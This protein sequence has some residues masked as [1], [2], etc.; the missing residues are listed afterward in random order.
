[1]VCGLFLLVTTVGSVIKMANLVGMMAFVCAVAGRVDSERHHGVYI[2]YGIKIAC[3]YVNIVHTA[4]TLMDKVIVVDAVAIGLH[5]LAS[6]SGRSLV[7]VQ[8]PL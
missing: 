1:L 4:V 6:E 5:L 8:E 7:F 3:W 2:L